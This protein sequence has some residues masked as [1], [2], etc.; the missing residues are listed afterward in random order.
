MP[1]I[2]TKIRQ[3]HRVSISILYYARFFSLFSLIF[4]FFTI[5]NKAAKHAA[6]TTDAPLLQ[7]VHI[8]QTDG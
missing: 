5:V 6:D 2:P 8:R 1:S 7:A 3:N 4:L